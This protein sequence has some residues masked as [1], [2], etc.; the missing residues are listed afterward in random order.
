MGM[1]WTVAI[2]GLSGCATL[3]QSYKTNLGIARGPITLNC[4]ASFER[5]DAVV[6][7]EVVVGE[8]SD[9]QERP[10]TVERDGETCRR[11]AGCRG[12]FLN[13]QFDPLAKPVDI[14]AEDVRRILL[15]T[16]FS[17]LSAAESRSAHK[18]LDLSLTT[19]YVD[20][21][22]AFPNSLA[23]AGRFAFML[24]L[25]RIA[26]ERAFW[27]AKVAGQDGLETEGILS[28]AMVEAVINGAYCDALEAFRE[29]VDSDSFRGHLASGAEDSG[30]QPGIEP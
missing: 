9:R 30:E 2:G 21:S 23:V 5:K 27:S 14:V 15:G 20:H 11:V 10:M 6:R 25:T 8:I 3:E 29:L 19:I 7:S 17:L 22:Y 16:G 12:V 13:Y 1:F 26:D 28:D 18:R 24:R 4:P